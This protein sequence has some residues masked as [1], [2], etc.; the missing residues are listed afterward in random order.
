MSVVMAMLLADDVG[1]VGDSDAVGTASLRSRGEAIVAG[2][3]VVKETFSRVGGRCRP[4]MADGSRVRPGDLIAEL[5]GPLAAIRGAAPTAIGVLERLS[6]VASG[7]REPDRDDPLDVYAVAFRLSEPR[8]V[9]DDG[10]AFHV[11]FER[12]STTDR[13]HGK[14]DGP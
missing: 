1:P 9:G 6:A 8:P 11:V 2:L 12:S 14:E 10:P 4:M 13:I 3:P 5:G 7:R